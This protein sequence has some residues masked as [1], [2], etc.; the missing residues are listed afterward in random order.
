MNRYTICFVKYIDTNTIS[1]GIFF[2][3]TPQEKKKPNIYVG[4]ITFSPDQL[5]LPSASCFYQIPI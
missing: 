4:L 5:W 2:H 1:D 3:E